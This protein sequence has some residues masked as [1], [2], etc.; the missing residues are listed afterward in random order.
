MCF[1]LGSMA[2]VA[3][4]TSELDVLRGKKSPGT[5]GKLLFPYLTILPK[6][7]KAHSEDICVAW[8]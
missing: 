6:E 2:E 3:A 1:F 5:V 7:R 8:T 4:V